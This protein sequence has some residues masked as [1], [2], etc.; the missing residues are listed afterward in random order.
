MAEISLL[1]EQVSALESK[2][3]QI[4]QDK[5][6]KEI[7]YSQ[8]EQAKQEMEDRFSEQID[9]LDA[10]IHRSDHLQIEYDKEVEKLEEVLSFLTQESQGL[11][12][13]VIRL[14][15]EYKAAQKASAALVEDLNKLLGE[16]RVKTLQMEKEKRTAEAT[17]QNLEKKNTAMLDRESNLNLQLKNYQKSY[18]E[19][20]ASIEQAQA[21]NQKLEQ[22][23][24]KLE[25][26][27][28]TS[29]R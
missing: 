23:V 25:S 12:E 7:A 21:K 29:T 16:E 27:A 11:R 20:I 5:T 19:N 8:M 3:H 14:S 15:A 4:N 13:D 26:R 6:L 17:F 10:K 22:T 24:R 9:A 2:I 1:K 18:Q 28:T